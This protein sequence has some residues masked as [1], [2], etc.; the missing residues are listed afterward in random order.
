[1]AKDGD[2]WRV[3]LMTPPVDGKANQA[4]VKFLAEELS[5]AKNKI[6]IIGGEK[7]REKIVQI[8]N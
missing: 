7:S 3:K 5:V 1:M 4:L 8:P 6:K 2:N